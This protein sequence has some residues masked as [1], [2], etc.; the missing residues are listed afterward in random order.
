MGAWA[1]FAISVLLYAFYPDTFFASDAVRQGSL[2][3]ASIGL[4]AIFLPELS[5]ELWSLSATEI[6]ALVPDE[7]VVALQRS[8]VRS[9]VSSER[10]ADSIID[11]AINPLV[12]IEADPHKVIYNTS[13]SVTVHP[14]C[15]DILGEP[16]LDLSLFE[17][18]LRAN[19]R[20]PNR[21]RA[22]VFWV[23]LARDYLSLRQE[24]GE[25]GCIYREI[26]EIDDHLTDDEWRSAALKYC[27][28]R[29]VI[30]GVSINAVVEPPS[31]KLASQNPR[32]IRWFF[33]SADLSR[34]VDRECGIE[35]SFD[36]VQNASVA[37][38]PAMFSSYY[39]A[40][41]LRFAFNVYPPEGRKC[42][43]DYETYL[44]HSLPHVVDEALAEKAIG[45][46]LRV[47]TSDSSLIWPGSGVHVGWKIL[48]TDPPVAADVI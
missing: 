30:D 18:T 21:D 11:G 28:A 26:S 40:G 5:N 38:F 36:Y 6:N 15:S 14:E 1:L 35:I 20:L 27:S 3:V 23:T 43:L 33:V 4:S 48:P 10:W 13:Y 41:G 17:C 31:E 46:E 24:Y 45:P 8:I 37:V 39:M 42:V 25:A 29:A 2:I 7:K 34:A 19:R 22:D 32:V 9:R 44:A 12:L 16:A 47:V